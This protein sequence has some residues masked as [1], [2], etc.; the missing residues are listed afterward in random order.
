MVAGR[1]V[2][3]TLVGT[4]PGYAPATAFGYLVLIL[5]V[6]RLGVLVLMYCPADSIAN[7]IRRIW[8]SNVEDALMAV[9]MKNRNLE[10]PYPEQSITI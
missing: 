4:D 5:V 9:H 6:S 8:S 10:G 2:M 3:Y 1:S 7:R